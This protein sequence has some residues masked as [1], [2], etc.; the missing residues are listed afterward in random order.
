MN[1]F[2]TSHYRANTKRWSGRLPVNYGNEKN[3]K[4]KGSIYSTDTVQ[5]CTNGCVGCYAARMSQMPNKNFT[6]VKNVRLVGRPKG[7]PFIWTAGQKPIPK[8]IMASD[9]G[10]NVSIDPMREKEFFQRSLSTI[11]SIEPRRVLVGLK[12][13]PDNPIS[14]K[15]CGQLAKMLRSIGYKGLFH[16]VIRIRD[17][18]TAGKLNCALYPLGKKKEFYK[19]FKDN[20]LGIAC[21]SLGGGYCKDCMFCYRYHDA[22]YRVGTSSDPMSRPEHTLREFVRMGWISNGD[23]LME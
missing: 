7:K 11:L 1:K 6:T 14:L 16:M 22:K 17:K 21:G 19:R 20:S 9:I 4:G 10:I 8:E 12:L 23:G 13:Y 18:K 15:R 2:K 3:G 5:G